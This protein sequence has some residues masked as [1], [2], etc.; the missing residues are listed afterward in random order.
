[1]SHFKPLLN[2]IK[3][4]LI[5]LLIGSFFSSQVIRAHSRTTSSV[6]N[7]NPSNQNSLEYISLKGNSIAIEYTSS[8]NNTPQLSEVRL[9]IEKDEESTKP[10]KKRTFVWYLSVAIIIAVTV[11]T[12]LE[13]DQNKGIPAPPNR[14]ANP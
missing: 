11:Y 9:Q 6:E 13:E 4:T 7:E 12:L 14:P 1:M 5:L 8:T 2:T 3:K 10:K